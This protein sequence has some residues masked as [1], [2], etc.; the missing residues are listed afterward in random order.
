MI[1]DQEG[2]PEKLLTS[3]SPKRVAR[4]ENRWSTTLENPEA[5]LINPDMEANI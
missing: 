2:N 4:Q 5:S 1:G 3:R